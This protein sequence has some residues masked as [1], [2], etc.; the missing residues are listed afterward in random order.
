MDWI[1][2]LNNVIDYIEDNLT[3]DINSDEIAKI[4]RCSIYNF[5]RMFSYIADK[6]LSEYIRTR[7]LTLAAFD[8][9]NSRDRILDIALKYGYESQDSFTRAFKNYH[10]VLP[11]SA[12]NQTVR[13][14]S[15][16]KISFQITIKGADNMNYQ[17]EQRP[18]F[19]IAGIRKNMATAEAF[20]IIPQ[21]WDT[22]WEDGTMNRLMELLRKNDCRPAGFLG[23][24]IGGQWGNS[25]DMDYCIGVTN[26]VDT[27]SCNYVPV[28]EGM[29][30]IE[31]P[32]V[33]WAVFNADGKLPD[34]VQKIYKQFYTEWLPN[35][36]YELEDLPAIESYMQDNRQEV[37]I[38]V[39]QK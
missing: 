39:K 20:Q 6:P 24:A 16:P 15:C 23:L 27:L 37:W 38:A 7:K 2:Q 14:K 32:S 10:G 30:E 22:A 36:G 21:I 4:A 12:R 1:K 28:P 26:Y 25:E 5:Q 34:A 13:L 31:I 19:K 3:G 18:A 17:I 29:E 33:T 8:I 11:S 35:S 9:I